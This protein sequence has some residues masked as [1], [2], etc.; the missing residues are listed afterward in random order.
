MPEAIQGTSE[1]PWIAS[2]ARKDEIGE[3]MTKAEK[4]ILLSLKAPLLRS[5]MCKKTF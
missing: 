4:A 5:I 1:E 2:Q 3:T